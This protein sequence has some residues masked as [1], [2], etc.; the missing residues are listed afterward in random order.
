MESKNILVAAGGTGGHIFPAFAVWDEISRRYPDLSLVWLGSSHRMEKDLIPARGIKFVGLRQT[1][2]RR[3]LSPGNILYNARSLGFL[4]ASLWQSV[5]LIKEVRPR[6]VLT[7][8]GFAGGAAGLAAWLTRTPLIVLEPNAFPGMTNRFLGKRAA[9]VFVAY[10]D[11]KKFFRDK[12]AR[13]AGSPAR[14]DVV[15]KDR[16]TARLSLGLKDDTLF[17]LATGGSQGATGINKSL[18]EALRIIALDRPDLQFRAVHQCGRGKAGSVAV[19]RAVLPEDRYSITEF[20]D[21]APTYL[22]AADIVIARAGAGT[23]SEIACRRL[24]SV[25]IPYA[26]SAEDHQ[27]KNARSWESAGAAFCIEEK[28]LNPSSLATVLLLLMTDSSKRAA[29][30]AEAAKFGDPR[31]AERIVDTLGFWLKD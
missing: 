9:V 22:A 30:G 24:P 18:P 29:M 4:F 12:T 1:E 31:A 21:D 28:D 20:I 6:L 15:E 14:R 19:D 3:G 26:H 10:P 7:T 5:R 11:A 16:K 8:G 27:V 17:L 2:F 13:V 23:L 25:L